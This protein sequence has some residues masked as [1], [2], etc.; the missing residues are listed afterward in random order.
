MNKKIIYGF[1]LVAFA[2]V[3]C[4]S[5]ENKDGV[6]VPEQSV[7]VAKDSGRTRPTMLSRR[8]RSRGT[9]GLRRS[10]TANGL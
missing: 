10:V 7:S 8:R 9:G 6:V 2:V 1:L 5:G 3:G 4:K